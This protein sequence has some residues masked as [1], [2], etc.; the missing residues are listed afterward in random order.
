MFGMH[1]L[2]WGCTCARLERRATLANRGI[3]QVPRMAVKSD[4]RRHL[5]PTPG[6]LM[7]KHPI[8]DAVCRRS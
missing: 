8:L 3:S 1:S 6:I 2:E 7:V 5:H 4:L